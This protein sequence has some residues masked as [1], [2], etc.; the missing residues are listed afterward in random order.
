MRELLRRVGLRSRMVVLATAVVAVVLVVGGALLAW[1]LRTV[2]VDSALTA[3]TVR[4]DE[5]ATIASSGTVPSPIPVTGQEEALAQVVVDGTVVAASD[6]IGGEQPLPI[7]PP[8]PGERRRQRPAGLPIGEDDRFEIVSVGFATETGVGVVH[9]VVSL[10]EID[11]VVATAGRVW[12]AGLPVLLAV[13]GGALWLVI[14]R[15][16][17]PIEAIR[18]ESDAIDAEDLTRRVPE[19]A[20]D[21]EVGRLATTMNRMLDR[22]HTGVQRQRRFV[23]D[24]AH[25]LRTPIASLRMQLETV[26]ASRS[27]VDWEDVT[28]DLLDETLRMQRLTEQLLILA[29]LDAGAATHASTIDLDDLV[30]DVARTVRGDRQVAVELSGVHPVQLS[31][32]AVLLSQAVHNLLDNAA[33]HA[34]TRVAVHL[35]RDGRTAVLR[36]DDDGPGLPP[37][38]REAVFERFVRVDEAR[39]RQHG[40]AGLGLAIVADIVHAHGGTVTV[41]DASGLGG[42][43]IEVVLPA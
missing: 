23:G 2:L 5:L 33:R 42:A 16:L 38:L 21:D 40:G 11:E 30:A 3:A 15:T 24:A 6:N 26:R 25:E 17:A 4:A 35:D 20:T 10:S 14:G 1:G 29:R 13:L 18:R 37:E 7:E 9:V 22:I 32:D 12:L 8:E 36:V 27:T 43:R 28:A 31:G 19:P 34:S 39:D 41:T